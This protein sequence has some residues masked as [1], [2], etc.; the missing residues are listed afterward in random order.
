MTKKTPHAPNPDQEFVIRFTFPV[1]PRL[2]S[3]DSILRNLKELS[4][5]PWANL[6]D[7]DAFCGVFGLSRNDA[8]TIFDLEAFGPQC[9]EVYSPGSVPEFKYPPATVDDLP[10]IALVITTRLMASGFVQ[11]NEEPPTTP[12]E[13][14]ERFVNDGDFEFLGGAYGL[15]GAWEL[16]PLSSSYDAGLSTRDDPNVSVQ[17]VVDNRSFEPDDVKGITK[18]LKSLAKRVGALD[19]VGVSHN[20]YSSLYREPT[21]NRLPAGEELGI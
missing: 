3:L 17:F 7:E 16:W 9:V 13:A 8:I 4:T 14:R 18:A 5:H 2:D 20:P 11:E 1:Y 19:L 10:G 6:L 21:I 12:E 15:A